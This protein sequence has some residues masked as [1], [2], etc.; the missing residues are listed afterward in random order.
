[1]R[2]N[3]VMSTLSCAQLKPAVAVLANREISNSFRHVSLQRSAARSESHC[4]SVVDPNRIAKGKRQKHW[5]GEVH[6]TAAL[7]VGAH[8]PLVIGTIAG[9]CAGDVLT[10]RSRTDDDSKNACRSTTGK[11]CTSAERCSCCGEC[12][13]E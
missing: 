10:R 1:M 5:H 12:V 7:R 6:G 11:S 2:T 13:S 8:W 4:G 3:A 9:S